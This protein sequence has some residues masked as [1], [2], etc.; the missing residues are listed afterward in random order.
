M[1]RCISAI[2]SLPKPFSAKPCN[3][4]ARVSGALHSAR[5]SLSSLKNSGK[6]PNSISMN[7]CAD[8]GVPSG[9]QKLVTIMC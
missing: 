5:S 7:C 4:L 8:I 9:C 1:T 2:C 3:S 6:V